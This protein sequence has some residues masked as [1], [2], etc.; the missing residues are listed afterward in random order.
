MS[1][2]DNVGPLNKQYYER[3]L[4]ALVHELNMMQRKK[5]LSVSRYG[6]R[7]AQ[8][9]KLIHECKQHLKMEF[10]PRDFF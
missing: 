7:L 1:E 9:R 10:F 5:P 8:V 2:W 6:Q 3:K 4:K